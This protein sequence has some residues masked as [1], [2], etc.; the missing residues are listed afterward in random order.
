MQFLLQK[1]VVSHLALVIIKK[2]QQA[3]KQTG[4]L[5]QGLVPS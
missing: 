4:K 3:P 1:A 5:L 2:P